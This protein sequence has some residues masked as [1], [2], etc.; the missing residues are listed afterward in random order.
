M[1]LKIT[2]TRSLIGR[3]PDQRKTA[4]ALGLHKV[5]H[6]VTVEKTNQTIGMVNKIIH[7]VEVEEIE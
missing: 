5:G 7:L 2:L 4:H 1:K 3:K 6:N